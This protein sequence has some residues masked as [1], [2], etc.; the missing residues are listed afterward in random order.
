VVCSTSHWKFKEK[1][2]GVH[3]FCPLLSKGVKSLGT[4]REIYKE[5]KGL[6][7]LLGT[8]YP[9]A[10]IYTR[11]KHSNM[12]KIITKLGYTPFFVNLEYETIWFR[13]HIGG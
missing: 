5:L 11:I 9:T 1:N 6:E 10:F 13:K 12:I 3:L 2:E 7:Q 4:L 8:R